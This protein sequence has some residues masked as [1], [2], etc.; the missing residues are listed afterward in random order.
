MNGRRSGIL[1]LTFNQD[2]T[3]VAIGSQQGVHIYN[4]DT[5]KLCYRHSIGAIRQVQV[6]IH[7]RGREGVRHALDAARRAE[8]LAWACCRLSCG[9]K[10]MEAPR[11]CRPEP[12]CTPSAARCRCPTTSPR[13]ASPRCSS[14]RVWW[15]LSG[16]VRCAAHFTARFSLHVS[17]FLAGAGWPPPWLHGALNCT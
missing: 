11:L 2:S 8:A 16:Q 13:T 6:H 12:E 5:H 3:C 7:T 10:G 15:A 1:F 14:A 4:V 17:M 9:M